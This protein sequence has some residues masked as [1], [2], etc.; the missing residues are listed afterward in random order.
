MNDRSLKVRAYA[1]INLFLDVTGRRPDGYHTV[2]MVM[3]SID[4]Q[5]DLLFTVRETGDAEADRLTIGDGE[6]GCFPGVKADDSNLVLRSV[7]ALRERF[8]DRFP[9]DVRMDIRLYKRIPPE[10]GLGGGSADAAATLLAVDRLLGLKLTDAELAGTALALGADVPF[11]LYGGTMRAEGIGEVLTALLPFPDC[12]VVVAKPRG[13]ASTAAIYRALDG[14][15]GLQHPSWEDFSRALSGEDGTRPA[16]Q[17]TA[18][19]IGRH[20]NILEAVTIKLV[21][22]IGLLAD[23][24]YRSGALCAQMT[25]SGSAVFGLF[26]DEK[27][28]EA[29]VFALSQ[30]ETAVEAFLCRPL[31]AQQAAD[32]RFED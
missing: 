23:H 29:A 10:A 14:I 7:R 17:C 19:Q 32:R 31:S 16:L 24:L 1:K 15:G 26:E 27:A 28:A 8:T 22:D 13:S 5:D 2:N 4:L 25:G 6:G 18:E 11:C 20:A 9:A 3:Q 30:T 12:A 21:P